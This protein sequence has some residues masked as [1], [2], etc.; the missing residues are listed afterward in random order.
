VYFLTGATPGWNSVLLEYAD[1]LTLIEAPLS[2][3]RA[4]ALFA[5]ARSL[6]P[7]KPLT[8]LVIS[9][10]HVDH[11]SGFRAAVAEGLTVITQ[12]GN[13]AFLREVARRPFTLKPDALAR[14]PK[15]LRLRTFADELVLKD[16]QQEARLYHVRNAS[17]ADT[18]LMVYLPMRRILV[19]ADLFYDPSAQI[20]PHV[21]LFQREIEARGLAVD[22][23][24]P[25]H[26][27]A[28]TPED[29]FLRLE[30]LLEKGQ[31]Q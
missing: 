23:H 1:H 3:A 2:E 15:P 16:K 24:V 4:E 13:A 5:A 21:V 14:E 7:R 26:G 25:L 31:R 22:L 20:M 8:E 18:L 10:F 12:E 28:P 11:A 30:K 19:N 6:V 17:H 9:H 27:V 29:D